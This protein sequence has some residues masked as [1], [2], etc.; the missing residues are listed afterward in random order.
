MP[1]A[2]ET[3]LQNQ[4]PILIDGGLG[5]QLEAQGEDIRGEVWS[6]AKLK[7]KPQA[8]V[9]A[10]RAFLDA[11]AEC[12][13]T[14]SYQANRA[15][16]AKLGIDVDEADAL[17]L[18]S[19]A[20]AKRAIDEYL[21]D[22]PGKTRP[23]LAASVGPYAAVVHNGSEYTG[24]YGVTADI[25]RQFHAARLR[26]L[27]QGGADLLA[28]ETVPSFDE[29]KVLCELLQDVKTPAWICFTCRDSEHLSDGTP[30]GDVAGLFSNHS[31]V[32]AV[33][34]N[35]TPPQY[36][37]PLIKLLRSVV[38]DKAI[39]VYPNSGETFISRSNS[40]TG[41]ATPIECG[42][43]AQEWLAAGAKIIGGCCR[44]GPAHI[45]AMREAL[46]TSE[47]PH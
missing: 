40:W 1:G 37:T 7:T 45:Q 26:L 43:A 6:A 19:I 35:C 16:F 33:G 28:C 24:D 18:S 41:T 11:G 17:I 46:A 31:R 38:P 30:I 34:V 15:G 10:H 13:I 4:G 9:D 14:A 12:V 2:F 44:M 25:I 36:I 32:L 22:N 27:D 47:N 5:T 42:A 23:L 8:I 29:A 39:I 21:R 3:R 20:L